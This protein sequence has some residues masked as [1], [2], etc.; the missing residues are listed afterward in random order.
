MPGGRNWGD[1]AGTFGWRKVSAVGEALNGFGEELNLFPD[2]KGDL[3]RPGSF[4]ASLSSSRK[5]RNPKS[6]SRDSGGFEAGGGGT[7][8]GDSMN[9]GGG[10]IGLPGD[11]KGSSNSGGGGGKSKGTSSALAFAACWRICS[12]NDADGT[13]GGG[14]LGWNGFGVLKWTIFFTGT[15]AIG[16]WMLGVPF[17][18]WNNSHK[19]QKLNKQIGKTLKWI[20]WNV[21]NLWLVA[22]PIYDSGTAVKQIYGT[23][24]V[25][26]V[27]C[28]ATSKLD[29]WRN[30]KYLFLSSRP[31]SDI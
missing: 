16:D 10:G 11:S 17:L 23:G 12:V 4:L 31:N 7:F 14:L 30:S 19:S 28:S 1:P 29:D 8:S 22:C 21:H 15:D 2:R 24:Q 25:P 6:G 26:G 18:F 20:T 9:S 5:S 27:W 13:T 3:I